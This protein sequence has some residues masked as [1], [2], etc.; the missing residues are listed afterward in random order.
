MWSSAWIR[1][2]VYV[3]CNKDKET[4]TIFLHIFTYE[5]RS[6]LKKH[7]KNNYRFYAKAYI[8]VGLNITNTLHKHKISSPSETSSP[9]TSRSRS[10]SLRSYVGSP[11][12]NNTKNQAVQ[13]KPRQKFRYIYWGKNIQHMDTEKRRNTLKFTKAKSFFTP[14][15]FV[16]NIIS[17]SASHILDTQITKNILTP[18]SLQNCS[19]HYQT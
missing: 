6:H 16:H 17:N 9:A 1:A 12:I 18:K 10:S 19:N 15:T 11:K 5:I 14:N 13:P 8:L 2:E 7:K 4:S 3:Q